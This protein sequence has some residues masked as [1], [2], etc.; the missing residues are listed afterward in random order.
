MS[1]RGDVI[2]QANDKAAALID[3]QEQEIRYQ[4]QHMPAGEPGNC[5][6]CGEWS[7]RLVR[8]V[9]APCRDRYKLP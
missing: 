4:A 2:D 7:G 1:D 9:C 6:L 3:A 5:D 8:G